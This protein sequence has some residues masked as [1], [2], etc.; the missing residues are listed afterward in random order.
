MVGGAAALPLAES[1]GRCPKEAYFQNAWPERYQQQKVIASKRSSL[2]DTWTR[3]APS[4]RSTLHLRANDKTP[5]L[6]TGDCH[7]RIPLCY[8]S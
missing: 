5:S 1:S 8:S 6:R 3:Y 2:P 7:L 4:T